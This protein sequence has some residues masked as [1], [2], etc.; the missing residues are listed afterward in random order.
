M[1]TKT[2]KCQS[3]QQLNSLGQF[4]HQKF[5]SWHKRVNVL[6]AGIQ[7]AANNVMTSTDSVFWWYFLQITQVTVAPPPTENLLGLLRLDSQ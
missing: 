2:F 4:T 1:P 3:H 5:V 6:G 7:I